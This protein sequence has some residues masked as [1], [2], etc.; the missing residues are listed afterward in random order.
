MSVEYSSSKSCTECF[1]RGGIVDRMWVFAS[2]KTV[3]VG[4]MHYTIRGKILKIDVPQLAAVYDDSRAEVRTSAVISFFLR[5]TFRTSSFFIR[6]FVHPQSPTPSLAVTEREYESSRSSGSLLDKLCQG[7][8]FFSHFLIH[9]ARRGPSSVPRNVS[10]MLGNIKFLKYPTRR[11]QP[12]L[13]SRSDLVANYF[14]IVY[15]PRV[16]HPFA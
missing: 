1:Y 11:V 5:V 16:F 7:L 8:T 13:I 10:V 2:S 9:V 6:T 15:P 3:S 14:A 4:E 12:L